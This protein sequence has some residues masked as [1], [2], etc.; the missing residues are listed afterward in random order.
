M[1][2]QIILY[3][4]FTTGIERATPVVIQNFPVRNFHT[5]FFHYSEE[6]HK[7]QHSYS[8][9]FCSL[10]TVTA[11]DTINATFGICKEFM[12]PDWDM[13]ILQ[14]FHEY[15]SKTLNELAFCR[16]STG[17]GEQVKVL[18]RKKK[19]KEKMGEQ[20][21]RNFPWRQYKS[22]CKAKHVY[23]RSCRHTADTTHKT[24]CVHWGL[25]REDRS[26][27]PVNPR[28][29]RCVQQ[30]FCHLHSSD[31]AYI[32]RLVQ[33]INIHYIYLPHLWNWRYFTRL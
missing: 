4:T 25:L 31:T 9:S 28:T 16:F 17:K 7:A 19:K 12:L 18:F 29:A 30:W 2:H 22:M 21:P 15:R 33:R 20:I 3:L 23:T 32:S 8:H 10:W 27:G 24:N 1:K 26:R 11:W 14:V 6:N 5:Q 13:K